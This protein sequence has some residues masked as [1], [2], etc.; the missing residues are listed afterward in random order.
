[1]RT[2]KQPLAV[3]LGISVA[4]SGCATPH[5]LVH[6]QWTASPR[7]RLGIAPLY[8]EVQTNAPTPQAATAFQERVSASHA[9]FAH[10]VGQLLRDK[11]F[12]LL[13]TPQV[14]QA[15]VRQE[16]LSPEVRSRLDSAINSLVD[17]NR[18]VADRLYGGRGTPLDVTMGNAVQELP[19]VLGVTPEAW[20]WVIVTGSKESGASYGGRM[21]KQIFWS[22]LMLVATLGLF[23]LVPNPQRGHG[24]IASA[25]VVEPQTGQVLWWN[26]LSSS[27]D[28]LN[29][30]GDVRGEL[31]KILQDLHP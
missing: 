11:P 23:M 30:D 8:Y 21:G 24:F 2:I 14:Y 5:P 27:G 12:T 22:L 9:E 13:N 3:A 16:T 4:L 18:F 1:M 17:A 19:A 15:L 26:R 20:L 31:R 29:V 7:Q 28:P 10:V 25:L 6:P